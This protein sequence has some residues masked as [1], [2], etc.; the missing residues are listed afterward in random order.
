MGGLIVTVPIVP[1]CQHLVWIVCSPPS[2]SL[3][4]QISLLIDLNS[5]EKIRERVFLMFI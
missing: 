4:L 3:R 5:R 1:L 2:K